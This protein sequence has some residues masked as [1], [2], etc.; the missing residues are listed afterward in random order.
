MLDISTVNMDRPVVDGFL[1]SLSQLYLPT[2]YRASALAQMEMLRRARGYRARW[3]L[4]PEDLE[5]PIPAYGQREYQVR[6]EPGSYVWGVSFF[7]IDTETNVAGQVVRVQVTDSCTETPF[8]SDYT[9]GAQLQ[10][11]H[12]DVA[13]N[14]RL[15][16][17]NVPRAPVLINPRLVGQP[18]TLDIELYNSADESMQVQL[19]LFVAEPMVPPQQ[20]QEALTELGIAV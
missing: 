15:T 14:F 1:N 19:V 12:G 4:A 13:D 18:G 16:V 3:Y 2:S 8:F 5:Q 9:K 10:T 7:G 17:S 6:V 20:I 11:A